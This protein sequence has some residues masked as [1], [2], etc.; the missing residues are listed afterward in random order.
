MLKTKS[1]NHTQGQTQNCT[2]HSTVS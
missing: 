2:W 1:A